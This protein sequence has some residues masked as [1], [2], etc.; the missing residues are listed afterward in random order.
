VPG[1]GCAQS[2]FTGQFRYG[3]GV[4]VLEEGSQF[5]LGNSRYLLSGSFNPGTDPQFQGKITADQARIEDIFA[6]LRWFELSDLGRL[7][8]G[9]Y[10]TEADVR[11]VAVG[12]PDATLLN[13]LR[14]Y[15]E[16]Q[17]LHRQEVFAREQS[18]FLPELSSLKGAFSGDINL[19][20]SAQ[21]GPSFNFDLAG[22][23]WQWG[24]CASSG[25]QDA[26]NPDPQNPGPQDAQNQSSPNQSPQT[27]PSPIRTERCQLYQVNQVIAKGEFQN[28]VLQLLP[29]RLESDNSLF[30]FTGNLGGPQQSGQLIAENIPAAAIRDL[31][32][33]PIDIQGD[34]DATATLGGSVSNPQFEGE[35]QLVN[36][37]VNQTE[38]IPTLRTLFGYN[39]AR[40]NFNARFIAETPPEATPA[41]TSETNSTPSPKAT[42]I[43]SQPDDRFLLT[44]SIPYKLPIATVEPD[45]YQLSVDLDIR[46]DGLSLINL[47]TD[48]VAW[49][50]GEGDVQLGVR[51]N[52][53][54][55]N[56]NFQSLTAN[57][58]ATFKD[59]T[60][61]AQ[62]LPQDLTNVNGTV[63]F[64]RDRIDVS[65]LTGKFGNGQV[66]AAGVLPLQYALVETDRDAVR[67]LTVNLDR[68]SIKLANIYDGDV[69][70]NVLITGSAFAPIIGGHILLSGGRIIVP[71]P[72]AQVATTTPSAAPAPNPF[73][74][75]SNGT[76]SPPA[77]EGLRV[78][79]GNRLRVTY[80][81]V[82]SFLVRGDL[83]VSGTQA[84]PLLD[85]TVNLRSGQVNLF[86][87]QFNLVQG[88]RNTAVFDSARGLDP[89]LDVRLV[90]SVPE[91]TR[92]PS[93]P[94]SPFPVSEIVDTPSAGS[95]GA[96]QTIR[97]QA[98]VTG[99]ASQVFNNL[100]LTSSPS[101]SQT[102][103]LAL[104]GGGFIS[105]PTS[106]LATLVGSPL[107]TGLQNLINDTLGLSDFRLF[108]TSI[109]SEDAR[110]TSLALAAELGV[111]ITN[112]FSVSVLQLLTVEE[113]P[114]FSLRYRL[115]D[116]LLL[117]GS[118]NFGNENRAVLEFE[119]RF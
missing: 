11:T 31:F 96:L 72:E 82:L 98:A 87:T 119:T 7:I 115:S 88:Y 95:F 16:I 77:F 49:K 35:L 48:Q 101:R 80:D 118:T 8:P 27:P 58:T 64:N 39:N 74:S 68:L 94:L 102:E 46:N 54:P 107:L 61:G 51:G 110:T 55:G 4:A 103:I 43:A 22:Q 73:T 53:P 71:T 112:D 67:P 108:P 3:N 66:T 14:R 21:A 5:R 1:P 19:Q 59:A 6:A 79:L 117:R 65:S 41:T 100:V 15:S 76:F 20:Y 97:V 63:L 25:N 10:G 60:I 26:Q 56:L 92:F 30:S 13:Q 86:T 106:T 91:V 83:L 99:P 28:G 104:L 109:I 33:L 32:R 70:G 44:G 50:G 89:I 57:G 37:V 116:N 111:D 18:S 105:D 34:L 17:A 62:A 85:G 90:T 75:R 69:E 114:Q 9:D 45:N 84:D 38:A 2:L 78:A 36:G 42:P 40:L 23:D 52:L 113:P 29:V 24:Q 47:F 81:P 12:R 93:Q